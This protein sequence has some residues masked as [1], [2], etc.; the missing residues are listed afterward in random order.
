VSEAITR[1]DFAELAEQV[2]RGLGKADLLDGRAFI[3]TPVLFPSGA[4]VVVVMEDEGG[5]WY[6]LSDLGQGRDETEVLGVAGAYRHQAQEVARLS[7]LTLEGNALVLPGV[8]AAQLVA[9]TMPVANAAARALERASLRAASR[10]REDTIEKLVSRLV[11]VFSKAQVKRGEDVRGASTHA[12][13]VDAVVTTG[14]HLA[15]FDVVT[16]HPAS[17]VWAR[18]K[19]HDFARLEAPPARVA[20]VRRKADLGRPA[21]RVVAG[22]TGGGGRRSRPRPL[23]GSAGRVGQPRGS[24]S[25]STPIFLPHRAGSAKNIEGM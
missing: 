12:W 11:T 6:R 21:G 16:S 7:G 3:R 22:G 1:T 13:Q 24:N 19:F 20:V 25:C 15:V 23:S 18:A 14:D 17:I 9:G 4:T 2:A 10:P 5:G 8:L